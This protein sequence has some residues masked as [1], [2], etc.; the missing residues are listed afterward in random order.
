MTLELG[1]DR[2]SL[3]DAARELGIPERDLDADFGV[4]EIDPDARRYAV[5]VDERSAATVRR[6]P[7]VEG[8][9]A[10]PPIEPSDPPERD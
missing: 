10:D 8:P 5:L 2:A 9:F 1:A 7:G 3:A 4:V 6:R